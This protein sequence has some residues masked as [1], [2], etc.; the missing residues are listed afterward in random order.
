[1]RPMEALATRDGRHFLDESARYCI[2]VGAGSEDVRID[3]EPH[4]VTHIA[5][6]DSR[7]QFPKGVVALPASVSVK[8]LIRILSV[9]G[10]PV[11][12]MQGERLA[13]VCGGQDVLKALGTGQ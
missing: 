6:P 2:G 7:E 3:N 1:M 4:A 8:T 12:L 5:D 9:S 11:L 13:G 10:H